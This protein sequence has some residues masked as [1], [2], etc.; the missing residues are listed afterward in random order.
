LAGDL[1][2]EF[3]VADFDDDSRSLGRMVEVGKRLRDDHGADVLRLGGAPM[4]RSRDRLEQA[5]GLPVVDPNQAAVA[6]ALARVR[7]PPRL[8]NRAGA[9]PC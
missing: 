5:V 6:M 8:R 9:E 1:S 2:A 3:G 4:A 7:L